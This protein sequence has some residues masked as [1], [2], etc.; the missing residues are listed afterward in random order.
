M[1]LHGPRVTTTKILP[2]MTDTGRDVG[3]PPQHEP[4]PMDLS[5]CDMPHGRKGAERERRTSSAI[6]AAETFVS[7]YDS[8]VALASAQPSTIIPLEHHAHEDAI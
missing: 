8:A 2:E 6:I 1:R 3:A 5:S 4:Y 7:L